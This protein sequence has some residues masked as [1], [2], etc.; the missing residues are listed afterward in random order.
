MIEREIRVLDLHA[1]GE[2]RT[3]VPRAIAYPALIAANLLAFAV[4]VAA[5]ILAVPLIG[6][7]IVSVWLGSKIPPSVK[8]ARRSIRRKRAQ[9][10]RQRARF[11]SQ[12]RRPPR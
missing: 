8:G 3:P 4:V 9:F 12:N 2:L 10:L 1:R 5:P 6:L 7:M 11:E